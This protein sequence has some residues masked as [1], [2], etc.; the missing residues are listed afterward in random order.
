MDTMMDTHCSWYKRLWK[1]YIIQLL[2]YIFSTE[3]FAKNMSTYMAGKKLGLLTTNL[4]AWSSLSNAININILP[5]FP[6]APLI[7]FF[8]QRTHIPYLYQKMR[9]QNSQTKQQKHRTLLPKL[10]KCADMCQTTSDA[11]SMWWHKRAHKGQV[12]PEQAPGRKKVNLA[13]GPHPAIPQS[14][15]LVRHLSRPQF[16]IYW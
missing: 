2:Y 16:M 12:R 1:G 14:W 9:D 3:A 15:T 4:W 8:L 10:W 7:F 11:K 6:F 5:F 13:L